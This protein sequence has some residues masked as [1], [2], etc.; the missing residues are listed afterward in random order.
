[1]TDFQ[2]AGLLL[3]FLYINSL[4]A[5][6]CR[7]N[8]FK[9][10]YR[11]GEVP[12]AVPAVMDIDTRTSSTEKKLVCY[13]DFEDQP[14]T[15]TNIK[16]KSMNGNDGFRERGL[17]LVNFKGC[18]NAAYLYSGDILF[19]GDTFQFKP[20][21]GV[22]IAAWVRI[23]ELPGSHSIFDTI[24]SSHECGQYHLEINDGNVRW[25]HR[26]ET[27]ATVF[28]VEAIGGIIKQS[29]WFHVAGTYDGIIG[30]AKIYVNDEL[31]NMSV[32]EYGGFLSLDWNMRVGIGDHKNY[33]PVLGFVDEFRIYNYPVTKNEIT[34]MFNK[35]SFNN[36]AVASTVQPTTGVPTNVTA[37]TI[38]DPRTTTATPPGSLIH[39]AI[40]VS[41]NQKH[42]DTHSIMNN[43]NSTQRELSHQANGYNELSH[44]ENGHNELSHQE[45]RHNE[46]SNLSGR[47]RE[48]GTLDVRHTEPNNHKDK[49]SKLSTQEDEQS[50]QSTQETV[51]TIFK[52]GKIFKHQRGN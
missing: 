16:D 15:G 43:Q 30:K 5:G 10:K 23:I 22:T 17:L 24:G 12:Q 28:S 35:C 46:L 1:M 32:N 25:F 2:R 4:E 27:Q 6:S 45:D 8:N 49:Q 38:L 9:S 33:R 37:Y 20:H 21:T 50:K 36:G 3:L 29:E 42:V 31:K 26:N 52:R 40:F 44:Q 39:E 34:E 41:D 11:R 7:K 51:E 18:G 14:E 48:V 19:H 13:L 47:Y